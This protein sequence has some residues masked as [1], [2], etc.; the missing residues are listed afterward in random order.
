M[1][2]L[3]VGGKEVRGQRRFNFKNWNLQLLGHHE[4]SQNILLYFNFFACSLSKRTNWMKSN[5]QQF[6]Q[7]SLHFVLRRWHTIHTQTIETKERCLLKQTV[8]F[9]FLRRSSSASLFPSQLR[10]RKTEIRLLFIDYSDCL[11]VWQHP[12]SIHTF[13]SF[14]TVDSSNICHHSVLLYSF[15]CVVCSISEILWSKW[16]VL[17]C[18]R[19]S[20]NIN[21]PTFPFRTPSSIPLDLTIQPPL[22]RVLL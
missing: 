1:K 2:C 17:F 21:S 13:H 16:V 4:L 14:L 5:L 3:W 12:R 18:F 20:V 9:W 11:V 15:F 8:L 19:S 22:T 7:T 10:L 6:R